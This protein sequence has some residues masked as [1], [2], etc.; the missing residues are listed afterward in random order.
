M[1]LIFKRFALVALVLASFFSFVGCQETTVDTSVQA[2]LLQRAATAI[3]IDGSDAIVTDFSLPATSLGAAVSWTSSDPA[4]ASIA[5]AAVDGSYV[6]TVTRPQAETGGVNTSITLT[7]TL[8]YEGITY[9]ATKSIRVIAEPAATVYTSFETLHGTATIDDYVKVQGIVYAKFSL[10]YFLVDTAGKFVAVY[11]TTANAALVAVGDLVEVKGSYAVYNTLYQISSLTSQV[12]VSS[13]HTPNITP[14][15]LEDANDLLDIN[16]TNKLIHGQVYTIEVTPQIRGS[17]DNVYLF[18]G[19]DR[20]ATVY[21]NS[22]ATSIDALE[23]VVDL[24]V[25]IDVVY[26]TYY[27]G[28]SLLE[29][30]VNE[31]YVIFCGTTED[32]DIAFENDT[33]QVDAALAAISFSNYVVA[34]KTLTLPA[35]KFQVPLTY[36]SSA[37]AIINATSGVISAAA[38][39][40]QMT[41]TLTV[42]AIKGAI[43]KSKVITFYVGPVPLETIAVANARGDAA[44]VKTKGIVVANDGNNV[45]LQDSTSGLYLYFGSNVDHVSKLVIGNEIEVS[46]EIDIYGG[47]YEMKNFTAVTVVTTAQPLPAAANLAN[48]LSATVLPYQNMLV[49]YAGLTIKTIPTGL[50]A[51]SKGYTIVLTDGTNDIPVYINKYNTETLTATL[52]AHVMSFA[53]GDLVSLVGIPVGLYHEL[54]QLYLTDVSML[55]DMTNQQKA[56]AAIAEV[57]VANIA[58]S[59]STQTLPTTGI[60]SSTIA[61]APKEV[62]NAGMLAVNVITYPLVTVNT[63][64]VWVATLT[65][66]DRTATKEFTVTV[67]D[68]NAAERVDDVLDNIID[69]TL[70]ATE[71]DVVTLPAPVTYET[72]TVWTVISGLATIDAG[73]VTYNLGAT[74]VVLRATTTLGT[75]VDYREFTVVVSPATILTELSSLNAKTGETPAWTV[76]DATLVYVRGIIT[77][78]NG[79]AGA[80]IQDASGDGMYCA[81]L[82]VTGLAVGDDIIVYGTLG[83]N[84]LVRNITGSVLKY[85]GTSANA[86]VKTTMTLTELEAMGD[87]YWDFQGRY[88]S[89]T[90][91]II[92]HFSGDYV[93]LNWG[94]VGT[95]PQYLS[96]NYKTDYAWWP[97]LYTTGQVLGEVSFTFY[98]MTIQSYAPFYNYYS[99]LNVVAPAITDQQRLTLDIA[100]LP[101]SLVLDGNYLLPTPGYGSTYSIDALPAA[102]AGSMAINALGTGFDV[103]MPEGL[104]IVN[105]VTVTVTYSGLTPVQVSIPVTVSGK[106][107]LAKAAL[108]AQFNNKLIVHN[109]TIALPASGLYSSTITW[110]SSNAAVISNTGV[111]GTV[112]APTEVTLTATVTLGSQSPLDV[113][114]VITVYA[115]DASSYTTGFEAPDF[116]ASTTYNNATEVALGPTGYKWITLCGTVSTTAKIAGT[117]S[118]QMRNYASVGLTPYVRTDFTLANVTKVVFQAKSTNGFKVQVL[119]TTDGGTTWVAGEIFTLT[120]TATTFTANINAS[121]NVAV[122][123]LMV[124][125]ETVV[126]KSQVTID[127]IQIFTMQ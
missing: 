123:F 99:I 33:A 31:V 121:G 103:T 37:P 21:Y 86:V 36:V 50:T 74:S 95:V 56:D 16:S 105:T 98:N 113:V 47:W 12:I 35:T 67:R 100:K 109:Q 97:S 39:T 122:K 58:L 20:V 93:Y 61:W 5:T 96:F 38:Q 104:N 115:T 64:F 8:T 28:S 117:N 90:G 71:L 80:W 87:N 89:I 22:L 18:A 114:L 124:Y 75:E 59:G 83:T 127:T 118:I 46:G 77:A 17:Y 94:T 52:N 91:L 60:Y 106:L 1:K 107:S 81:G 23:A 62:A 6:V 79:T 68:L 88:V 111:V 32:I 25:T 69:L 49:S 26:Y 24:P 41:V 3:I 45:F 120:T 11:T 4:I 76:A 126:D 29:T 72:A 70:T 40:Q 42:T 66:V 30:G 51:T 73:K 102:Y 110:A 15:V 82:I 2:D 13:G 57:V 7:A 10:G 116:T 44:L 108:E 112:A 27:S 19:S 54:P 78:L 65:V 92:S 85:K 101:S 125:P 53:V 43:T 63:D 119:Y 55:I 34:D 84:K 14:I 9:T 48:I